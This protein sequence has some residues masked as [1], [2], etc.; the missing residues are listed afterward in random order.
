MAD[1]PG[2]LSKMTAP[3]PDPACSPQLTVQVAV[4]LAPRLLLFSEPTRCRCCRLSTTGAQ[5]HRIETAR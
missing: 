1:A 4:T 5:G 3:C 2:V